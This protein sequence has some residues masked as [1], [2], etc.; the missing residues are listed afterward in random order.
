M[1]KGVINGY[2]RTGTSVLWWIIQQSNPDKLVLYEPHSCGLHDELRNLKPDEHTQ[3]PLHGL[4]IYKPY[5]QIPEDIRKE[6]MKKAKPKSIYSPHGLKDAVETVEVFDELDRDVYIQ[7]NQLHLILREFCEY[8]N[9]KYIHIVRDPSEVLYAHTGSPSK[10][11]QAVQEVLITFATNYMLSKWVSL[12]RRGK[13]ELRN[14]MSV[15]RRMGFLNHGDLLTKFLS[16]YI[17]I[18][19]YI[20][21]NMSNGSKVVKFETIVKYPATFDYVLREVMGLRFTETQFIDPDK[22]FQAPAI[23]KRAVK[24]RLNGDLK[25]KLE[26]LGYEYYI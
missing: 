18:N 26:V 3:N 15:A 12:G 24:K 8:F 9:C 25:R 7:S 17:N 20:L 5:F 13:F 23:L 11:K 2:Y 22:A 4:P 1:I 21:E 14:C 19:Y 6:F 16:M 10:L